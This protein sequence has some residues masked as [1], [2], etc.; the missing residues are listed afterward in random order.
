MSCSGGGGGSS[1]LEDADDDD[2]GCGRQM[3]DASVDRWN[4]WRRRSYCKMNGWTDRRQMQ[5]GSTNI[6]VATLPLATSLQRRFIRQRDVSNF[7]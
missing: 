1:G 4:G 7:A 2:A 6:D 5:D 3:E